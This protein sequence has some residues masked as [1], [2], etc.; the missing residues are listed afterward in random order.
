M[1]I[2]VTLMWPIEPAAV[3]AGPS[4]CWSATHLCCTLAMMCTAAL[5]KNLCQPCPHLKVEQA[6]AA[7]L[8]GLTL[9]CAQHSQHA[10]LQPTK[11]LRGSRRGGLSDMSAEEFQAIS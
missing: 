11:H 2:S 7:L 9:C 5:C 8:E 4:L 6:V 1:N 10:L 3:L